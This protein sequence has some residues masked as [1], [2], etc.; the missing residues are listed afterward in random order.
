MNTKRGAGG[1]LLSP[2]LVEVDAMTRGKT[3][4]RCILFFLLITTWVAT[5]IRSDLFPQPER[6]IYYIQVRWV[7]NFYQSML[8]FKRGY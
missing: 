2:F 4:R 8:K 1:R 6:E 7:N 5:P 3:V